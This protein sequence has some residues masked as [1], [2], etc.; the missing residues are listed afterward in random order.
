MKIIGIILSV[1][2]I[3]GAILALDIRDS[4]WQPPATQSER[5]RTP[6][7]RNAGLTKQSRQA[8]LNDLILQG[9]ILLGQLFCLIWKAAYWFYLIFQ[10]PYRTIVQVGTAGGIAYLVWSSLYQTTVGLSVVYSDADTGLANPIAVRNKSDLFNVRNIAWQCTILDAEF[11][12]HGY[13]K[14]SAAGFTGNISIITPGRSLNISC[15]KRGFS[16]SYR[17]R[18][19][20]L[21]SAH[22]V[23]S[24]DYDAD[25]F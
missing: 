5:S 6:R 23:I 18:G 11:E 19:A 14:N 24:I 16:E 17:F 8:K 13:I 2:F 4:K 20:K 10:W 22:I 9:N 15:T 12:G 25:F 1:V 21:L 3:F 7:G